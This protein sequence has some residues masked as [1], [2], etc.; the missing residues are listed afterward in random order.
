MIATEKINIDRLVEMQLP[1]L[2]GSVMRVAS[3]AQ[4]INTSA[5]TLADAIGCDPALATRVLR[6]VNSPLYSM[7]RHFTALPMAVNA[8]GNQA[9]Y[10]LVVVSATS[11]AFNQKKG[12]TA[13]EKDLWEHA[14]TVGLAAREISAALGMRA[15]EETFLCGLLHDIGKLLLLRHDVDL[16]KEVAAV[17][18]DQLRLEREAE[19]YGFNHAQIGALAALRWNLPDTISHVIN[20]HHWPS[21]AGHSIFIV[22]A[23]AVADELAHAV[24][25][26]EDEA[27]RERLLASESVAALRLTEAQLREVWDKTTA[28]VRET[29]QIFN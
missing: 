5:R 15:G 24:G 14:L 29:A 3:L 28:A 25:V 11:E 13:L 23:I 9:I 21:E 10:L 12:R 19:L 18:D 2:P 16:Y 17:E 4:D 22:R 7:E 1:P 27:A 6:A 8:L 20:H 26:P